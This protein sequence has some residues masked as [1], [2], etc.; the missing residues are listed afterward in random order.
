MAE[1]FLAEIRMT[2]FAFAPKGWALCNGQLLPINQNQAL[3][4][5]LGTTYGGNGTTTF[6]LPN[7]TGR[8]PFHMGQSLTLGQAAGEEAVVLTTAQMPAHTH[9]VPAVSSRGR[10]NAPAG[11]L[12]SMPATEAPAIYSD[13]APNVAM[14]ASAA[15][16]AAGQSVGHQ[17]RPPYLAV[18]FVIA[19]QGIF[20]SQN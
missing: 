13:K 10:E 1:P 15:L 7:L 12:W 18:Y 16:A 19:L 11:G 20:P 3:F 8:T 2:S 6:A 4:A 9:T 5:L 14:G 17:N